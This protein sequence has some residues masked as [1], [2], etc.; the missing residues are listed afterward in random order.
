MI[1]ERR[2]T[3]WN[4]PGNYDLSIS[5]NLLYVYSKTEMSRSGA[6][7]AEGLNKSWPTTET[8]FS[9]N[10]ITDRSLLLGESLTASYRASS[11]RRNLSPE[12]GISLW[13]M[14]IFSWPTKMLRQD[15]GGK[16]LEKKIKKLHWMNK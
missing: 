12:E 11:R 10:E 14:L 9:E 8:K 13:D 16:S 4:Y 7:G 15:R 6:V 5:H 1:E 2:P 3:F